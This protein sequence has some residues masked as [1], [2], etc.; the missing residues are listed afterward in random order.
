MTL[1]EAQTLIN[2]EVAK[3]TAPL[4]AQLRESKAREEATR[5]LEGVN[6]P[7]VSKTRI[8]ERA[9][10][11]IP[12]KDNAL[13]VEKFRE[14]VVAEAKAEGQYVSQLVGSGKVIGLGAA[15]PAEL[16]ESQREEQRKA[17]KRRL[18]EAQ[19]FVRDEES[20]FAELTGLPVREV[21]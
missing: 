18:K 13:D 21:A 12:L 1:Q 20:V 8:I 3:A 2:A 6:L 9:V 16:T 19:R 5:I 15:A 7:A 10:A 17:E 4:H 14:L 11:A